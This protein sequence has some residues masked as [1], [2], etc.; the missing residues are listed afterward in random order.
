M[1]SEDKTLPNRKTTTDDRYPE[2]LPEYQK[3][4]DEFA[5]E[6]DEYSKII[7]KFRKEYIP[8]QVMPTRY[9]DDV[10]EETA[11]QYGF[12]L[13]ARATN[14]LIK[15]YNLTPPQILYWLLYFKK[16]YRDK[17]VS[18]VKKALTEYNN[19]YIPDDCIGEII[20]FL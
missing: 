4:V 14:M 18:C 12:P 8:K 3:R 9:Y 2:N 1:S 5:L 13:P 20:K 15:N 17:L 19:G 16:E 6:I 10:W 7:N 11:K